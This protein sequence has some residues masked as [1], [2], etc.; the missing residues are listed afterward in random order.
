MDI[1]NSDYH[2]MKF[3]ICV[4]GLINFLHTYKLLQSSV[5]G[6]SSLILLILSGG[7]FITEMQINV[8][9]LG[10]LSLWN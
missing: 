10:G 5:W 3:G 8:R 1:K 7:S 4:F 2:N 9:H 6:M